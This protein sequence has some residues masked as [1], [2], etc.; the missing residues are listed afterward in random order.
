LARAAI[1]KLMSSGGKK[2]LRKFGKV[3]SDSGCEEKACEQ[4]SSILGLEVKDRGLVWCG[5]DVLT[6][7]WDVETV[8]VDKHGSTAKISGY[9]LEY[10]DGRRVFIPSHRVIRII[11]AEKD[12]KTP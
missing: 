3:H 5:L 8:E 10:N 11:K 7:E 6:I 12:K 2:N 1:I 9:S 4:G